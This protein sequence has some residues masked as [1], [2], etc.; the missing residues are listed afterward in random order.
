MLFSTSNEAERYLKEELW[1]CFKY[2][3]IPL[4]IL[5]KMPTRD[6]KFYIDRHNNEMNDKIRQEQKKHP[7]NQSNMN[8]NK[9]ADMSQQEI[10]NNNNRG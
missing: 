1:G 8:I 2:I 4:N 5:Y 7:T 10:E 9:F 6:R 3:G